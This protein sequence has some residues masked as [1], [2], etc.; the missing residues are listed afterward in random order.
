MGPKKGKKSKGE[1]EEQK[2]A[3]E[4]QERLAKIAEEKRVAADK[5]KQRL[6]E[7]RIQAERKLFRE[8]EIARLAIEYAEIREQR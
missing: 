8:E 3:R 7:L 5:E 6:E 1:T 2:V 4:E